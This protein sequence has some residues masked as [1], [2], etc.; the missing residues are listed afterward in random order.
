MTIIN[1]GGTL[2]GGGAAQPPETIED[3]LDEN[4]RL[5]QENTKL[6]ARIEQLLAFVARTK[7]IIEKSRT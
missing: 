2:T 6:R 4:D 3:I 7:K 5:R 1:T